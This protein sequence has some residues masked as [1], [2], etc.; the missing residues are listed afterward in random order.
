MP[1][2]HRALL[3]FGDVLGALL[4]LH[5]RCR[6]VKFRASKV[7]IIHLTEPTP[8]AF[9]AL[10]PNTPKQQL[11]VLSVWAICPPLQP[12]YRNLTL[13]VCLYPWK[14]WRLDS[15][16]NESPQNI[17]G[18]WT[19]DQTNPRQRPTILSYSCW[20]TVL[21]FKSPVIIVSTFSEAPRFHPTAW[22][23]QLHSERMNPKVS[24]FI[25]ASKN[26]LPFLL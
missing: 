1:S 26:N 16:K 7:E 24:L 2:R 13:I 20:G 5:S 12:H 11:T 14:K 10:G 6:T 21:N 3:A 17:W 22:A 15:I 19:H 23:V 8:G 25:M 18:N 9:A 4:S